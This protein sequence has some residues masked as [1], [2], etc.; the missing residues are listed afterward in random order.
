MLSHARSEMKLFKNLAYD[1]KSYRS[2]TLSWFKHSPLNE[3]LKFLSS[4]NVKVIITTDHGTVRVDKPIKIVGD[5]NTNTNL[6]FKKGKNLNF[7]NDDLFVCKDP[8]NFM[9]PQENISTSYVFSRENQYLIYPQDYYYYAK[10]FKDSFQHGGISLEEMIIPFI[11]LES[12]Y[13]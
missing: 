2:L 8:K 6:R 1:E 12:K 5:N 11:E 13:S 3:V 4:H 7:N 10:N 9:L